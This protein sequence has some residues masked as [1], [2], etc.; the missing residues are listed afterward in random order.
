V[1]Y[2]SRA[3]A[4]AAFAAGEIDAYVAIPADYAV[5]DS[6][7]YYSATKPSDAM[8]TA[9]REFMRAAQLPGAPDWVLQRLAEPRHLTYTNPDG[10]LSVDAT[11]A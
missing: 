11:S 3:A 6:V 2:A 10:R 1:A 5:G 8:Q 4:Q 9:L 7:A